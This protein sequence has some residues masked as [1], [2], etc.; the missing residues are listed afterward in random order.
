MKHYITNRDEYKHTVDI[1]TC[2]RPDDLVQIRFENS[3]IDENGKVF[4]SSN[5]ELFLTQDQIQDL[6][7]SLQNHD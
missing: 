6:I 2:H 7:K 3:S 4:H 5:Y 1:K